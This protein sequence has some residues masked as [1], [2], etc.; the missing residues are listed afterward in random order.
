MQKKYDLFF[1]LLSLFTLSLQIFMPTAATTMYLN[2]KKNYFAHE[3]SYMKFKYYNNVN[4]KARSITIIA[5]FSE[6]KCSM[7]AKHQEPQRNKDAIILVLADGV[8]SVCFKFISLILFVFTFFLNFVCSLFA[9][10][11]RA[12][13]VFFF[14]FVWQRSESVQSS[15]HDRRQ[16]V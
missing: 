7:Q 10:A 8:F 11:D 12:V 15:C 13:S 9:T 16:Y 5:F 14:S 2:R 4:A 3:I 1:K 6:K